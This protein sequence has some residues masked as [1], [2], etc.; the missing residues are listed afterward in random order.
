VNSCPESIDIAMRP[1]RIVL[2][3][4]LLQFLAAWIQVDARIP[5]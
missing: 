4:G 2:F 5:A 3:T 1:N